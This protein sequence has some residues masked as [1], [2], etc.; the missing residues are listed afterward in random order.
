MFDVLWSFH[1][2]RSR[3][4]SI[5]SATS[6]CRAPEHDISMDVTSSRLVS[7]TWHC[8]Q[9]ARTVAPG[10]W[11]YQTQNSVPQMGALQPPTY[12]PSRCLPHPFGLPASHSTRKHAGQYS[13]KAEF[14][15]THYPLDMTHSSRSIRK[16][17]SLVP[18]VWIDV[19][20]Q[21]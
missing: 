3:S 21:P 8:F 4:A 11:R 7:W 5:S 20:S 2:H 17:S 6:V 15:V 18:A 1:W 9:G 19:G 13:G 12:S 10:S 16:F 14:S